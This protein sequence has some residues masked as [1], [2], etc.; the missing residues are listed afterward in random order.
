M[1][2]YKGIVC[3]LYEHYF[4]DSDGPYLKVKFSSDLERAYEL[5]FKCLGYPD[6]VMKEITREEFERFK[7]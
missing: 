7:K 6:E 1:V 4:T 5:G 2:K 3:E